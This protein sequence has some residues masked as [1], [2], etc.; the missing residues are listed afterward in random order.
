MRRK[1]SKCT[2]TD[3]EMRAILALS[4]RLRLQCLF[5]IADIYRTDIGKRHPCSVQ[6][7]CD[8]I[9]DPSCSGPIQ[10]TIFAMLQERLG[11]KCPPF[12]RVFDPEPTDVREVSNG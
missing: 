5:D 12:E 1:R 6:M 11:S 9:N 2:L 3:D 8:V 10:R 4:Q 7:V